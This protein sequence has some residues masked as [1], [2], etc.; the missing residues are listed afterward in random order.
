MISIIVWFGWVFAA[1]SWYSPK[2]WL[3]PFAVRAAEMLILKVALIPPLLDVRFSS[4][5]KRRKSVEPFF[6]SYLF[7]G[8]G[9][10]FRLLMQSCRFF[11]FFLPTFHENFSKT[12]HTIFIKFCSHSTPKGAPA[13]AKAS[14]SYDWNV[15]NIAKISPKWP[16]KQPFSTFLI[17]QKTV[18]TIRTKFSSHFLHHNMVL[19]VQFQ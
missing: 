6:N 14:K 5:I 2:I 12:V 16:K 8:V 7:L 4:E 10:H 18:H 11:V 17:F 13:C 19:C 1:N 9:K 15:R 3:F